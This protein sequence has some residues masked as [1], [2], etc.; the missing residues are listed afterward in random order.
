MANPRIRPSISQVSVWA[1][2]WNIWTSLLKIDFEL[3]KKWQG[4]K[5]EFT[6]LCKFKLVVGLEMYF[7]WT[8]YC[9]LEIHYY[10]FLVAILH[11]VLQKPFRD[12]TLG[13]LT[14]WDILGLLE[15]W[16]CPISSQDRK[17]KQ[18]CIGRTHFR[19]I[20]S[21]VNGEELCMH[22]HFMRSFAF[23]FHLFNWNENPN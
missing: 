13:K 6:V 10:Q 20:L 11:S 19:S 21:N 7:R 14:N 5:S 1:T 18:D 17:R 9:D 23:K 2:E 4:M 22:S 16:I 12:Q 8:Q 3:W 15:I